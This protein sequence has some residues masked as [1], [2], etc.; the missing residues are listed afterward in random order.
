M[1]VVI[2]A[3]EKSYETITIPAGVII[4]LESVHTIYKSK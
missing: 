3:F 2:V 1:R 4:S